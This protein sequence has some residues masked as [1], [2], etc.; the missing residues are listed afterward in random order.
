[1]HV[2]QIFLSELLHLIQSA[3]H[4]SHLLFDWDSK[5]LSGHKETHLFERLSKN[6]KFL[7][8]L[9]LLSIGPKQVRQF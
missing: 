4:N 5:Y 9:Q 6:D 3:L 8:L 1:M 2:M 7:Q